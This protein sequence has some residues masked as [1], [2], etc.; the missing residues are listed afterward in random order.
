MRL[1]SRAQMLNQ[2]W[3]TQRGLGY[4][5]ATMNQDHPGV[6]LPG[7]TPDIYHSTPLANAGW[8]EEGQHGGAISALVVG[9]VEQSVPTLTDMQVSRATIEI[10]RVIP[11]V[12]LRIETNVVREGKRIQHVEAHVYDEAGTLLCTVAVQRLRVADLPIPESSAPPP[13]PIPSPDE[14]D[15]RVGEAWGVGARDSTLFHRHA[16]EIREVE[17]GFE[18]EGPGTVWMRM[19]KPIVAGRETTPL[20]RIVATADFSNGISRA[21]D[22]ERWVFMNPDLTVHVSRYPEAEWIALSAESTYG[23][24]GRGLATGTLWDTSGWL[25]RSSQTLYVDQVV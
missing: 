12:P 23:H 9:H 11:L 15:G 7:E 16:M 22:I 4:R 8:Y 14:I 20:E 21:L 24:E 10:F 1:S 19:T 18:Q 3:L 5:S 13:L 2:K 6:Y 25:G 17:G